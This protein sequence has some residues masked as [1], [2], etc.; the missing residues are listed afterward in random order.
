MG[1]MSNAD[2]DWGKRFSRAVVLFH[3]AVGERLGLSAVDHRALTLIEEHAPL[4]ASTLAELTGLTRGAITG[5]VDRLEAAGYVR[6]EPDPHDRRSVLIVPTGARRAVGDLFGGLRSGMAEL[7]AGFDEK[8][9]AAIG[10]WVAGT[11]EVLHEETRRL[12]RASRPR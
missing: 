5:L 7:I 1:A 6:R 10:R 9:R 8:E 3:E 4:T 11:I 12:S 2:V